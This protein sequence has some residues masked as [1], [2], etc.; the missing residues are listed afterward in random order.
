MRS[1]SVDRYLQWYE[2]HSTRGLSDGEGSKRD[3]P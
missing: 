2:R 3:P 1:L